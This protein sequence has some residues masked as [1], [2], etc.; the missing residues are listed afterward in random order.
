MSS[1][2]RSQGFTLLEALIAL[3]VV[4][5]AMTAILHSIAAGATHAAKLQE[6]RF[7]AWVAQ[8]R[9]AELRLSRQWPPVQ[10]ITGE[11]RM[12]ND[13]WTWRQTVSQTQA[14]GI[15]RVDIDVWRSGADTASTSPT[16]L[17]G[18]L[19]TPNAQAGPSP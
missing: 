4:A 14:P 16:R 7:A 13:A 18:F 6:R 9:L 1:A 10:Q 19:L 17:S 11:T 12:A 3:A 5:I 2:D 15:R 8:N